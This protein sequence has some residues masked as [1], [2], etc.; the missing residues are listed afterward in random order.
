MFIS[1]ILVF[2]GLCSLCVSQTPP[3][4]GYINAT[5]PD[6]SKVGLSINVG[7]GQRNATAPLLYGWMIEDI[8][9]SIDGG[10][11]GELIYNR[12]FQGS[13]VTLG[14]LDGFNGT[15][16]LQSENPLEPFGPA[17]QGWRP[18]GGAKISL[19]RVHPLSEALPTV[20]KVKFP[21]N[22]SGEVGFLNEGFFGMSVVPQVYDA[23]LY[24]LAGGP[25]EATNL[26]GVNLSLRS[27]LTRDIWATSAV[28]VAN[29][30][31]SE[32]RW[33]QL[34]GQIQNEATA[35]NS[36]NTF[37]VTFNGTEVAGKTYYFSLVSLF[38]PTFRNRPNG[39]RADLAETIYELRPKFLRFPGELSKGDFLRWLIGSA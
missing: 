35:P 9:H 38:P 22:A 13:G 36:N 5:R 25:F 27:N 28:P 11:Y 19:D 37:A 18:I 33:T 4:V 30:T 39:M 29:D 20:M 8:S 17:L 10:L 21:L 3:S 2:I 7:T 26:T 16:I 1:I 15:T 6:D 12:A 24:I 23:S 34:S 14:K 31:I 32:N